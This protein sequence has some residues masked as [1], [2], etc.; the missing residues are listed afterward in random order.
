MIIR[1]YRVKIAVDGYGD[2]WLR[3][4]EVKASM[5]PQYVDD[6]R[7]DP[8]RFE[9]RRLIEVAEVQRLLDVIYLQAASLGNT[10]EIGSHPI[11]FGKIQTAIDSVLMAANALKVR[12]TM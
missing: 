1:Q 9:V 4:T 8:T 12:L 7:R 5:W 3:W 6:A 11:E 10:A 2:A